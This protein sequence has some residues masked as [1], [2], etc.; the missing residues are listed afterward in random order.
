VYLKIGRPT[1][2]RKRFCKEIIEYFANAPYYETIEKRIKTK[3]GA[4]IVE[5]V[6]IPADPPLLAKFAYKI[7]ISHQN[8]IEWTKRYPEFRESYTRAKELQEAY[9]VTQAATKRYDGNFTFRTLVNISNWTDRKEVKGA[10]TLED[11]LQHLLA[12]DEPLKLE[13]VT[14]EDTADIEK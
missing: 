4:E 8:M 6:Q 5:L 11:K 3:T 13:N 2:Y 7:G 1:K 10:L 9:F 12:S 14:V